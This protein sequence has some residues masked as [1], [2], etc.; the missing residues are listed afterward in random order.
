MK[1]KESSITCSR[2]THIFHRSIHRHSFLFTFFFSVAQ[3]LIFIIVLIGTILLKTFRR[4]NFILLLTYSS[5][6]ELFFF[7]ELMI[8]YREAY[9]FD[10]RIESICVAYLHLHL[11]V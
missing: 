1:N 9:G 4:A 3:F 10:E 8:F 11:S 6:V 7:E 2:T 5:T